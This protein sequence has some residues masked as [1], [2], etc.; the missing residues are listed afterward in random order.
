[1][2]L[3]Q[4]GDTVE[5]EVANVRG[6]VSLGELLE[7]GLERPEELLLAHRKVLLLLQKLG[8]HLLQQ[9]YRLLRDIRIGAAP[10]FLEMLLEVRPD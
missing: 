9:V 8:T 10:S 1:M 4:E 5:N 6:R 3:H 7:D 2:V